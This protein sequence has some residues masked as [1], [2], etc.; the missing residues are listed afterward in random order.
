MTNAQPGKQG[1]YY[2]ER[3][4]APNLNGSNHTALQDASK[5]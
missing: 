5:K 3:L 4:P 1:N 2:R